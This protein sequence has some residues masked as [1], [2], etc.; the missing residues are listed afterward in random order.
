[1]D[2]LAAKT[3]VEDNLLPVAMGHAHVLGSYALFETQIQLNCH[4]LAP[5]PG[6]K[7]CSSR[8]APL[9]NLGKLRQLVMRALLVRV[10]LKYLKA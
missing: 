3:A 5:L 8:L 4:H 6:A 2:L 7:M 9:Q 1:L 10:L